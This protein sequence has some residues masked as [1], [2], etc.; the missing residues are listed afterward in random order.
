MPRPKPLEPKARIH[1]VLPS[2]LYARLRLMFYSDANETGM[3]KGAMSEF[4]VNA[5]K[6]KLERNLP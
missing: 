2:P 1:I 6:E 5:I 3:M 4:I